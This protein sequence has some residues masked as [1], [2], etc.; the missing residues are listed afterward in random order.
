[1]CVCALIRHTQG[2]QTQTE[3]HAKMW[4]ESRLS[5]HVPWKSASGSSEPACPLLL[6]MTP[7][8]IGRPR[9]TAPDQTPT[10][11]LHMPGLSLRDT[12]LSNEIHRMHERQPKRNFPAQW[13]PE[14]IR[15]CSIKDLFVHKLKYGHKW[16]R[17][18]AK[19][20][21][22]YKTEKSLTIGRIAIIQIYLAPSG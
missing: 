8:C 7:L 19:S 10:V 20:V 13:N 11:F 2:K 3:W 22:S 1:M 18:W 21:V 6:H 12:A 5:P 9:V 14:H 17:V 4:R 15:P 16:A